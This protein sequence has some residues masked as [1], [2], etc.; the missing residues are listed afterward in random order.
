MCVPN[1]PFP[2]RYDSNGRMCNPALPVGCD[3]IDG[4]SFVNFKPTR[5][6][7]KAV[8]K[9]ATTLPC[10]FSRQYGVCRDATVAKR[11]DRLF[12][13]Q[14]A[15]LRK[16]TGKPYVVDEQAAKVDE[17]LKNYNLCVVGTSLEGF[18]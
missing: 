6:R 3:G 5:R 15:T 4:V 12:A 11:L 7:L 2:V 14:R 16:A 18:V 13:R 8:G 1:R 17:Y 9:V 10:P